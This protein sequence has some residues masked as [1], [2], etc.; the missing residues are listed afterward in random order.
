MH[1]FRSDKHSES[2]ESAAI[3]TI[4]NLDTAGSMETFLSILFDDKELHVSTQWDS[5][6]RVAAQ[7]RIGPRQVTH[8]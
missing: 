8:T 1:C 2:N 4:H 3:P 6:T 7:R 5:K